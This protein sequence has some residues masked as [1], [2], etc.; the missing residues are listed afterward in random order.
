LAPADAFFLYAESWRV[1]QTVVAAAVADAE[2][3]RDAL[4]ASLADRIDAMPWMRRT[5][6][7]RAGG[8]LRPAW[9]TLPTVELAEHVLEA[10]IPPPGGLPGLAAFAAAVAGRRLPLD[11]PLWRIWVLPGLAPGRV[12]FIIAVHHAVCDG[13]AL[14][15]LFG[16]LFEPPI[17]PPAVRLSTRTA[18]RSRPGPQP[19]PQPRPR[20]RPRLR[21]RSRLRYGRYGRGGRGGRM[22]GAA[23]VARGV[24]LLAADG[25]VRAGP[26]TRTLLPARRFATASVPLAT[27]RAAARAGG[28]QPTDVVLAAFSGAVGAS[29]A[30]G[31]PGSGWASR[32]FRAFRASRAPGARRART[33]RVVVPVLAR[34]GSAAAATGNRT[35]G[36]WVQL[37][38][39]EPD[40]VRRLARV[41]ADRARRG[42]SARALGARFVME[43]VGGMLP[44]P[45]HA[46][47]VRAAY[48]GRFFHAIV[49]V[50]PGPRRTTRLGPGELLAVHPVLPL[51]DRV[52][53]G[54]GGLA[55]GDALCLGL[56]GDAR[57]VPDPGALL[58]AV[59]ADIHRMA[60]AGGDLAPPVPRSSYR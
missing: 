33:L 36:L 14:I 18:S 28:G 57:A 19:Q 16:P 44:A 25:T 17:H 54:L 51:A 3:T 43:R 4:L 42:T 47:A 26:F 29:G 2:M 58:D 55:W 46:L 39:D 49:S 53:V 30:I 8:L 34:A 20:P 37:P 21:L 38:L 11:R 13:P 31:P 1:P 27:V 15:E 35:A 5:L 59:V 50:M 41:A 48:R 45:L 40:P 6:V 10:A 12:G 7:R 56:V 22:A 60:A 9:R 24:L 52:G 32:A 23:R